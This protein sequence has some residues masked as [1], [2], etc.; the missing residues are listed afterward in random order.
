MSDFVGV[1]HNNRSPLNPDINM[2]AKASVAVLSALV[3][4]YVVHI[5]QKKRQ[6]LPPGPPS[7]PVIGQILSAP[8]S[9]EHLG[10]KIMS[11]E[12]QSALV[13]RIYRLGYCSLAGLDAGDIICLQ[14]FGN[15]IIILHSAQSASDLFDKRSSIYSDRTCPTF[16]AHEDLYVCIDITCCTRTD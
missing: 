1:Y 10:Y 15:T 6:A 13:A 9:S 7:Y 4:S 11:E 2:V 8:R 16:I 5:L 12:L 14:F 3:V